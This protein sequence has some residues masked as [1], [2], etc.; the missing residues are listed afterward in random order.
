MKRLLAGFLALILTL[1]MVACQQDVGQEDTTQ[2]PVET[3]S[4]EEET[5]AAPVGKKPVA[6]GTYVETVYGNNF[7]VPFQVAVTFAD[8]K[9]SNIEVVDKGGEYAE[10]D[11]SILDSAVETMIPRILESQSVA[12]DT[13]SGATASSAAI[14]YAVA[15][16]IDEAGGDSMEWSVD[17]PKSTEVVKVEGYDVIVVGL[18]SA[19]LAAYCQAAESGAAVFGLDTAAKVG[20]TS[21]TAGGPMA[22]NPTHDTLV[23][24]GEDGK[25]VEGF[26]YDEQKLIDMWIAD[27]QAGEE[28]GAKKEL[29][30]LAVKQSG[31]VAD[32][33]V[34]NLGIQYFNS[35]EFMYPGW[36]IYACY[37]G[38]EKTPLSMYE[39]ALAKANT[40]NDKNKYQLELTGQKIMTDAA[41]KV[42][43]VQ[44]VS[45]DG[46]TYEIYAPAVILCTGGFGGSREM[47][48]EYL[49]HGIQLLGMYQNDGQM[50][51]AALDIGA[52]MYNPDIA[53]MNHNARTKIDLHVDGIVPSHQKALTNM[54]LSADVLA[55][56]AKG[57][58][59]TAEDAAMGLGETS[60]KAGEDYYVI[61]DQTYL[62]DVK[63]NGFA[64]VD[65][66]LNFRD[67]SNPAYAMPYAEE[68]YLN[69]GDPI[70]EM[71]K[72][73]EAGVKAGIVF[74]A[75]SAEALAA[76]IGADQLAATVT[77]YNAACVAG[78]DEKFGKDPSLLK[79]VGAN[80]EKVYAILCAAKSFT[81]VGGLD[82]NE[83]IQV[84][85]QDGEVIEGLYACGTDSLGV[86]FSKKSGYID[87]G[88]VAHSW[89]FVSGKIA[90][91]HAAGYAAS[92]K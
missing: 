26:P 43:G 88:G 10:Y 92:Q 14:R 27:T 81:T 65:F 31:P 24:L 57:E 80:G 86:L 13:I 35:T 90:G 40:L 75:D 38:M 63:A 68:Y 18:G 41:G 36:A 42:C 91:E 53:P 67:F 49:G 48:V 78:V 71:D 19:G 83:N 45:Y 52:A 58:R 74:T 62:D 28:K 73:I 5:T 59:F 8:N 84:L 33:T 34:T 1:S 69:A 64:S 51:Q 82:V 72:I 4:K 77:E 3:T 87:Y 39:D 16:A 56:N 32:W 11:F 50:I 89:C 6:D 55:V 15:K 25:V 47:C 46:T 22:V 37:N 20:G 44:A 79:S 66:M 17:I 70:T 61:V 23:P 60:I 7:S 85:N 2:A 76:Q 9:I 54:A 21:L 30:E 12:V 29:I